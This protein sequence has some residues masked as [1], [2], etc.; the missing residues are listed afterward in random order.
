M[1]LTLRQIMNMTDEERKNILMVTGN[2][3]YH[4]NRYYTNDTKVYGNFEWKQYNEKM[5]DHNQY[6]LS[7]STDE[8]DPNITV[9]IDQEIDF[10]S[11]NSDIEYEYK[12]YI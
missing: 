3:I 9:S 1:I 7:W 12:L 4:D 11:D 10:I 5:V 2:N 8:G 6:S